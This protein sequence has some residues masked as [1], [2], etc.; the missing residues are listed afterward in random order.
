M[1]YYVE[2]DVKPYTLTHSLTIFFKMYN[3]DSSVQVTSNGSCLK[4]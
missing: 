2:W 1:T 4:L 3:N